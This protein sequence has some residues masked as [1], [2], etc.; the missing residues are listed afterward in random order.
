MPFAFGGVLLIVAAL[1]Q[2]LAPRDRAGRTVRPLGDWLRPLACAQVWRFGLYYVVFFG[3]YVALSLYLPK[4]YVDTFKVSLP[5]AGLLTALFIFPASLL[6]P[7]GGHLSDRFGPR[8]VTVGAFAAML[9]ALVPLALGRFP[10]LP[11]LLALT[12]LLGVGMGIGKA[13]TYTLVARWFP[14]EMG[15]VG[16]L[17]GLLGGLGGFVLP[18]V[19]SAL[20]PSLG[21]AAAFTTLLAAHG[22]DRR[23]VPGERP[24]PARPERPAQRGVKL[25]HGDE[26]KRPALTAQTRRLTD[27]PTSGAGAP[28]CE[29]T[30]MDAT[31][32]DRAFCCNRSSGAA[33]S[34]RVGR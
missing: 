23:R 1:V 13:S 14:R 27:S 9:V 2:A 19:F 17:V 30:S 12:L 8:A 16:G 18:L 33:T 32:A 34:S 11:T 3:A 20:K 22:P 5:G 4:F 26:V 15:V 6:R 31:K 28:R 24:A 7:L 29:N 10:A 25:T 21:S